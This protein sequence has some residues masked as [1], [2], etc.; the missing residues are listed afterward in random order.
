MAHATNTLSQCVILIAF[1]RSQWLLNA[2]RC[3][4]TVQFV[5]SK[6][7]MTATTSNRAFLVTQQTYSEGRRSW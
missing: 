6:L 3:Y 1:P 4:V 2:P 5:S 7:T